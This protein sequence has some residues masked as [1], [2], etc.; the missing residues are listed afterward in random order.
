MRN[1]GI[2]SFINITIR[3]IYVYVQRRVFASRK[4]RYAFVRRALDVDINVRAAAVDK[5]VGNTQR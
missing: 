3:G 1:S 2:F 5:I 4:E